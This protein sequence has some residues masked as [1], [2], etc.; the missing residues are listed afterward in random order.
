MIVRILYLTLLSALAVSAVAADSQTASRMTDIQHVDP[1]LFGFYA[2]LLV[3]DGIPIRAAAVVD[4]KA[5]T[6]ACGKIER[7]LA[8]LD[9]ASAN[10]SQ[11]GAELHIIGRDQPTSALPE[12]H[13]SESRRY[14]DA[15]GKVTDIDTRTRGVGGLYASCGEEN[16]LGLASDRYRGGSDTCTHEFA[17][18]LMNFG[19]GAP[20]RSKIEKQYKRAVEKGL[21][22]G[23]YAAVNADEYFAEL[24]M[25]YFGAHGEFVSPGYPAPGAESLRSYDPDG[26]ALLDAIYSGREPTIAIHVLPARQAPKDA[27]SGY[28]KQPSR[29][30][31]SNHTSQLLKLFWIDVDGNA[32][33]YGDI[34]SYS[35]TPHV[36]TV[37]S[38][39][40]VEDGEG[41]T[42]RYQTGGAD[43][44]ISID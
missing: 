21:W 26:Y 41:R 23:H 37:H 24:S 1:P 32:H 18:D 28:S 15:E 12:H 29:L 33:G 20:A 10:L 3:C 34:E 36:T 11:R 31:I 7:M 40:M 9:V 8:H 22:K 2:K 42:V 4:D 5:I 30:L 13:N 38:V 14:V 44:L 17:H 43:C 19:L 6:L 25:W 16:L 35:L 39:W 27:R